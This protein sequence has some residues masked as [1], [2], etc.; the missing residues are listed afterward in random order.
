MRC[1][2]LRVLLPL[3]VVAAL[4][5][6][7]G[8]GSMG[9][10][11]AGTQGADS[12]SGSAS[13]RTS[14]ANQ[15]PPLGMVAGQLLFVGGP[16]PGFPRAVSG[17][18]VT[19]SGART[20]TTHVDSNGTFSVPLSPG[21]YT[22]TATSANYNSGRGVCMASRAVRVADRGTESVRVYCQVK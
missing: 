9:K 15:K 1:V 16:A 8:S 22:V 10:P 4:T 5:G 2:S 18:T 19:F 17:G 21:T 13:N 20:V 14:V 11:L 7:S 6:C 3:L 12:T